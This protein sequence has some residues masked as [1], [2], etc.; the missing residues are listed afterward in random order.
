MCQ[1]ALPC[2]WAPLTPNNSLG[3]NLNCS[4]CAVDFPESPP[5]HSIV[6][7]PSLRFPCLVMDA[8]PVQWRITISIESNADLFGAPP[9]SSTTNIHRAAAFPLPAITSRT[10]CLLFLVKNDTSSLCRSGS[11]SFSRKLCGCTAGAG[12][13]ISIG[14]YP[15]SPQYILSVSAILSC[16]LGY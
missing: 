1:D 12:S 16:R 14:R 2:T 11:T 7:R 8:G 3:E 9:D 6:I 15:F 5:F 13:E 10:M 4:I